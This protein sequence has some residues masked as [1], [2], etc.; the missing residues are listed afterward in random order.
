MTI[1]APQL[2]KLLQKYQKA[3]NKLGGSAENIGDNLGKAGSVL[4]TFQNFLGT[5]LSSMKIDEL[6]KKQN[7]VAMSA[8]LNWQ[9]R[10]LS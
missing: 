9:K 1:F 8:L 4:S 3:G 10:V 7:L 2:D 6:I 5:A